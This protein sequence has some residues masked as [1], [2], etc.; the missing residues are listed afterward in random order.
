M[1]EIYPENVTRE[2]VAEAQRNRFYAV[3]REVYNLSE[4]GSN[5]RIYNEISRH[6]P[7]IPRRTF[8]DTVSEYR[9]NLNP[10]VVIAFCKTFGY[11]LYD[12][13][14]DQM[15]DS[16]AGPEHTDAGP[17][18]PNLP[19]RFYGRFY[20]Y[21]FNSTPEYLKHGII[22]QF[23]LDISPDHISLVLRHYALNAALSNVYCP[24]N[25]PL[26][27]RIIHNPGGTSPNGIL[28][29]S[30][31]SPN[32][33]YFCVMAYNKLQLNG[34]LHFRR[35]ALLIQGRGGAA[36]PVIQS[37]LFTDQ[38]IDLCVEDNKRAVQGALH[39][40]SRSILV[41]KS[42]L[43]PFMDSDLLKKYFEIVS[44]D[45]ACRE[46][47]QL[48]EALLEGLDI[49]AGELYQTLFQIRAKDPSAKLYA[50]PN[51]DR[52]WHYIVG[53]CGREEDALQEL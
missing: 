11:D 30:F 9:A 50:F 45:N 5:T 40:A 34:D 17:I 13:Y 49:D 4:F 24:R 37:F 2:E 14:R 31:T 1:D 10:M 6:Y 48:D 18:D 53:L 23:T 16:P 36:V 28:T 46:Y 29:I 44:Y 52:S 21:F 3:Y 20:G 19:E 32:D 22:D 33:D 15:A 25:I 12:I 7:Y 26:E 35:G 51:V 38:K 47:I 41:K 8:D 39:L 42:D 43:D 27:G